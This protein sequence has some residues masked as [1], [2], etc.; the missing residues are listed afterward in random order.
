[1]AIRSSHT[2]AFNES[3]DS[4]S[5]RCQLREDLVA[6]WLARLRQFYCGLHGHDRLLQF[7]AER[8]FLQCV[9]CGHESPGWE[10]T[11][12]PP[13]MVLRGD[14]RRHALNRP[15]LARPA[16]VVGAQAERRIA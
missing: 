9:S 3:L 1:M 5:D 4:A 11:E 16:A 8:M 10:L 15:H 12:A 2:V 13:K 6:R 14:A 7:G